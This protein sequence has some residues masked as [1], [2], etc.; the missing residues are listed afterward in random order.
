[1]TTI[2]SAVPPKIVQRPWLTIDKL[3]P[4]TQRQKT[5]SKTNRSSSPSP[6]V[7]SKQPTGT[8]RSPKQPKRASR[9]TQHYPIFEECSHLAATKEAADLLYSMSRDSFPSG[10]SYD[11]EHLTYKRRKTESSISISNDPHTALHYICTF[12]SRN[13]GHMSEEATLIVGDTGK[14]RPRL[15][16]MKWSD[17]RRKDLR[18]V[19]LWDYIR[20]TRDQ[21]EL[22]ASEARE[23]EGTINTA[24]ILGHINSSN[25]DFSGGHI[26]SIGGL[27]FDDQTR[28]IYFDYAN[29]APKA[30]SAK[31]KT[32]DIDKNEKR[33]IK[34]AFYPYIK[35]LQKYS[36]PIQPDKMIISYSMNSPTVYD[37]DA[38]G[39]GS[40]TFSE[41]T[42]CP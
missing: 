14:G 21:L 10:Y 29:T 11:G 25:V 33:C 1:M 30:S 42:S 2:P 36:S 15:A 5:E 17:V 27:Y 41:G 34:R 7:L 12:M 23:L 24:Y 3:N 13:S 37:R 6:S 28:R 32:N 39:S 8:G 26:R 31:A 9:K 20:R 16:D 35:Y 18:K 19:L 4:S 40:E 38:T 22:N